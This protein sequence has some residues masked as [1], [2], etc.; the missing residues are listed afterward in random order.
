MYL[1][2]PYAH[3]KLLF[4][5]AFIVS[6]FLCI[7]GASGIFFHGPCMKRLL[8][9]VSG[10]E[11]HFESAPQFALHLALL[12]S[13][14]GDF[15]GYGLNTYGLG[16]SLIMLEMDIAEIIL[17]SDKRNSFQ[18]KPFL[19]KMALIVKLV[20]F[21]T[22]TGIFRLGFLSL[23]C[24]HWFNDENIRDQYSSIVEF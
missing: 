4:P 5:V 12:I 11:G 14:M 16:T 3:A 6:A 15:S 20:P 21:I 10:Y 24:N 13:G 1:V 18:N 22:L 17:L 8:T 9:H 23:M 19:T 7:V 2:L